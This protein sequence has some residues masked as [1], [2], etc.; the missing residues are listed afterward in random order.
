MSALE[1][2]VRATHILAGYCRIAESNLLRSDKGWLGRTLQQKPFIAIETDALNTALTIPGKDGPE[3]LL[4]VRFDEKGSVYPLG[5][6]LT[7]DL[8]TAIIYVNG[9]LL[10]LKTRP[11]KEDESR[12]VRRKW[13]E[14][15]ARAA[16]LSEFLRHAGT[17]VTTPG[18]NYALNRRIGL[19]KE[20]AP[21]AA[22]KQLEALNDAHKQRLISLT[23]RMASKTYPAALA[24]A[25]A[26]GKF[27]P[28]TL[29]GTVTYRE[30]EGMRVINDTWFSAEFAEKQMRKIALEQARA[31]TERTS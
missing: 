2:L 3:H 20:D 24:I 11:L 18:A 14:I 22:E 23:A 30:H 25:E 27:T 1:A 29:P 13:I 8:H 10:V 28:V 6:E 19:V 9:A 7:F 16:F 4:A 15:Y 21:P 12:L 26:L 31:M 5:L 17:V